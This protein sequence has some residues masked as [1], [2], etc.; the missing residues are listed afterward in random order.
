MVAELRASRDGARVEVQMEE[1]PTVHGDQALLRQVWHNLLANAFKFSA[2]APHPRVRI[3][4]ASSGHEVVF[5][6]KDNGV[7]F[8]MSRA[9]RLFGVFQRLHP[10]SEFQGTGVG[11]SIV[12]RIVQ[13][14]RGRVGARSTPGDGAEFFFAL[15][16]ADSAALPQPPL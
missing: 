7:G 3:S 1:L 12:K 2:K 10:A 11:L 16:V 5:T 15:P 6:V 14:H 8:E 4:A 13:R 9:E